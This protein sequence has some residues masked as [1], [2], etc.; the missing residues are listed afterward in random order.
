MTVGMS[1]RLAPGSRLEL[2]C[3]EP[4]AGGGFVARAPDGR[5]VFVRHAL[6]GE[7][8]VAAV[9]SV[10]TSYLRADAVEVL[11]PSSDRV[12][13]PC[14]YAGPGRCGGCDWQHVALPA[15]RRL[16]SALLDAQLRRLPG[17]PSVVPVV[18]VPGTPDG[19]GWRTRVR[20][21]V[22]RDGRLGFHRHRSRAV[23][24]VRRCA[25]ASPE[26][27]ALA[28]PSLRWRGA[29]QVEVV[30]PPGSGPAVVSVETRQGLPDGAA[31]LGAG[32]IRNGAVLEE[33]G[34]SVFDVLGHRFEVGAGVFWQV[35]PKAAETL[36]DAV[37][38]LL[39][40]RSGDVVADLYAGAGLFAAV[41]AEAVGP[42]GRVVAVER[43]RRACADLTRNTRELGN[44]EV[45][46]APVTDAL[47]ATGIGT[48]DLVVLDPAR[49]GAGTA[50]VGALVALDPPPRRIAYVSCDPASLARDLAAA[51]AAGWAVV[52]IVAFDLFP[53]TEHLETVVTLAPPR[54]G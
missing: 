18:E 9:T 41:L 3:G 42:T 44:V 36:A 12:D 25:I 6:P 16:K 40:P 35:H 43:S 51:L 17:V 48:P 50:V 47:V 5:I 11:D 29:R 31:R 15:Q 46:E 30:A 37:L 2:T 49:A 38:A 20:F 32:L 19:T 8:V 26:A 52:S 14:P 22:D 7:R 54:A 23:E 1:D 4:A 34:H 24:P 45:H 13:P 53:M 10:T 39:E 28:L 33:P 21:A 27:D